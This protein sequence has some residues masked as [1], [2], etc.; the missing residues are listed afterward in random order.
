M[1]IYEFECK[2][3]GNAFAKLV[4]VS[5]TVVKCPKCGSEEVDKKVSKVT[6]FT[7]NS[8]GCGSSG[9]SGFR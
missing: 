1:P 6:S 3:C 5:S 8:C 7:S 2:K 4:L 9:S